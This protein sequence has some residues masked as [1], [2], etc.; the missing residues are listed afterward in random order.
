MY[1]YLLVVCDMYMYCITNM[2]VCVGVLGTIFDVLQLVVCTSL[3]T[4]T[5]LRKNHAV[6]CRFIVQRDTPVSLVIRCDQHN[7]HCYAYTLYTVSKQSISVLMYKHVLLL[8]ICYPLH[9]KSHWPFPNCLLFHSVPVTGHCC[10]QYPVRLLFHLCLSVSFFCYAVLQQYNWYR[11]LA[12]NSTVHNG[13]TTTAGCTVDLECVH[14][15]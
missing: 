15:Q 2:Y 8:S 9:I 6:G 3:C 14:V 5:L 4:Q 13:S 7:E 12:F 1:I 11:G 10:C